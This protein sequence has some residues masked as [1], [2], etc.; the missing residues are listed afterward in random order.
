[1]S[2][3]YLFRE[4][5]KCPS[6][7]R[8]VGR[9]SVMIQV[10][11]KIECLAQTDT[12]V[13][14]VGETGTGKEL[15]AEAIH[16]LS[17]RGSAPIMQVN[18]SAFSEQLLESELFGHVNG[19]FTGSTRD[20]LGRFEAAQGG[21]LFLDEIGD[22][23]PAI[24]VSLLRV[25]EQKCIERV[26]CNIMRPLDVR[27]IT[28]TNKNLLAEVAAGRFRADLFYRLNTVTLTL[29]PLRERREDI[30]ALAAH[31]IRN[32]NERFSRKI[33]GITFDALEELTGRPWSGNVREL[34]NAIEHAFVYCPGDVIDIKDL[35]PCE[36]ALPRPLG[37]EKRK[38]DRRASTLFSN[39]T[40]LPT[41]V[42]PPPHSILASNPD[43]D[44][45]RKMLEQHHWHIGRTA[46][47]LGLHR[48]TLWRHMQSLGLNKHN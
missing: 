3:P 25:L 29:P 34:K 21:T 46:A 48:T 22:I 30:T 1:M 40:P 16:R 12:T 20:R 23:S 17:S 32:F 5:R 8:L 36:I 9:S 14:I 13:L 19:A 35:G 18:C 44:T 6:L 45:L 10:Y 26:G 15:A 38:G 43:A 2:Q 33:K 39:S 27:V 4:R 11:Q 41:P 7:Y 37:E 47:A 31:F 24:Q 28:A 42:S